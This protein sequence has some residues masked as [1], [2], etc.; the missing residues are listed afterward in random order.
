VTPRRFARRS[1][2]AKF[3]AVR[4]PTSPPERGPRPPDARS[5]VHH[6]SAANMSLSARDRTRSPTIPCV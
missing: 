2:S 6:A 1:C 3:S 4:A 5:A